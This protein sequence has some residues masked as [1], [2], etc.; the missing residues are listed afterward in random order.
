MPGLAARLA[1]AQ[2]AAAEAGAG[3]A[4][5]TELLS[6]QTHR[7]YQLEAL[8]GRGSFGEV[9]RCTNLSDRSQVAV[10][11]V[12]TDDVDAIRTE[13]RN[14]QAAIEQVGSL[15]VPDFH[16][17]GSAD[18]VRS[19][20]PSAFILVMQLIDG[21][22]VN[23][24]TMPTEAPYHE[25]V[26]KTIVHDVLL[27]LN[28]LHSR[29]IVH[30]DVKPANVMVNGKGECYL[31][32]FGV[33][34][35]MSDVQPGERMGQVGSPL[36]MAP[37]MF[38]TYPPR[39]DQGMDVWSLGVMGYELALGYTPLQKYAGEV[40]KTQHIF[41]TLATMVSPRFRPRNFTVDFINLVQR[42]LEVEPERRM[43]ASDLYQH[44]RPDMRHFGRS[45]LGE[46]VRAGGS[47]EI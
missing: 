39:Y 43:S 2:A 41:E 14:H 25:F 18:F 3:L 46:M 31:C 40:L 16:E 29:G 37:E 35:F 9:W 24:L 42:C 28:R 21:L 15:H 27:A 8:L 45:F 1:A 13:S 4:S 26:A 19:S 20:L 17:A 5:G 47:V 11:I 33:S 38:N 23:S 22:A 12:R 32:D 7:T 6:R 30:R 10:K 44:C 34:F 36:Y